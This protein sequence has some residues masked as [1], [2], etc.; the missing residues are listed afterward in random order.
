MF[1]RKGFWFFVLFCLAGAGI[2]A[3]VV[4]QKLEPYREIAGEYDLSLVGKAEQMSFIN[5]RQGRQ[6]G[7]MFV[8]NRY[9][10]PLEEIPEIFVDAV[11]AQED[12]RFYQHRG[13]DWTGVARAA[14]LNV[15]SG[16][17]TQGAGTITMQLARKSFDLLG[18]ARRREW[19]GY[20]RKIIEAF[21]ALKIEEHAHE[22]LRVEFGDDLEGRQIA[23]KRKLLEDYLNLVPFG[24]GF[25]G[26]RSASLGYFGKEPQDLEIWECASIVACLKNPVRISPL[27][28]IEENQKNRDHVIRRMALEQMIT[29]SERDRFLKKPVVV[30]PKP[31][32]RGKSYFYELVAAKARSLVGEDAL[33]LGGYTIKTTID[34]DIQKA[35]E[36]AIKAQLLEVEQTEGY[37]HTKY[38][39][40]DRKEGPPK[41]LQGAALM[42]DHQAG[43]VLAHVGGRDYAHSQ[44]DFIRNGRRP[45]GTGY[46][47]FV[48]ASA[49]E[50]GR[51][52]ASLVKDQRMNAKKLMVGGMVGV[53]G[54]WG[55]EILNPT[56]EDEITSREALK[57]S[58]ISATVGLGLELGLEKVNETATKFGIPSRN[59]RLLS[60]MLVGFDQASLPEV[61]SAYSA[62][63]RGGQRVTEAQYITEIRDINGEIVFP[64]GGQKPRMK[65]TQACSEA[66]AYQIHSVL[67]DVLATG[68][69]RERSRGLIGGRFKGGGKSGTPYGFSDAWMAGYSNRV[70]CAV[71]AGFY[72]GGR[73]AIHD[74][75]FAKDVAYPIWESMMN[76]A[77]AKFPS[78]EIERPESI[79]EVSICKVSGMRPT[80]YC[81]EE[82]EDGSGRLSY[83]ST[84]YQEFLPRG[85]ELGICAVHGGGV[86]IEELA[87]QA[88]PQES[89][90]TNPIKPQAPLLL[91]FDPYQSE[92]PTLAPEDDDA[93][94][95]FADENS[96]IVEDRVR[97]ER[98]ALLRIRRPGRFQMP[99]QKVEVQ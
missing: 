89:F 73:K 95:Y 98:Q 2:G 36:E 96:L 67:N 75:A 48:Y 30:D 44:F 82:T 90:N 66:V 88:R 91:G 38:D 14:Y 46:F 7:T 21:V 86:D 55:M 68:N 70:T 34:A 69:L 13:V 72:E 18:E 26:V 35:A 77:I 27:R 85:L 42:I 11:L 43:E 22:E 19:S 99:K 74:R 57:Q 56:Y 62:F 94:A 51:H 45:L 16:S 5:D 9:S 47:P 65:E 10:L 63:P 31:I 12:Q 79:E 92:K 29:D 87:K 59:E 41:Y 33:S 78:E 25:Y 6:I 61:V 93:D 76:T 71:W 58:K 24:S 3:Y 54:E 32:R 97:G 23:V 84:S 53:V 52:G 28:S 83:R 8:E 20:E 50:D 40:Y 17:V 64:V 4:D 37:R 81:N 39:D 1:K 80:R 15:K 49:F 60:R